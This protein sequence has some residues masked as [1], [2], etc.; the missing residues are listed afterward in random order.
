MVTFCM[1]NKIIIFPWWIKPSWQ[2]ITFSAAIFFSWLFFAFFL[3]LSFFY[4]IQSVVVC[5]SFSFECCL[6]WLT[7]NFENVGNLFWKM[8][9]WEWAWVM[10]DS[11]VV[12]VLNTFERLISRASC[13][14]RSIEAHGAQPSSWCWCAS[15]ASKICFKIFALERQGAQL[16]FSTIVSW[17]TYTSVRIMAARLRCQPTHSLVIQLQSSYN[18]SVQFPHARSALCS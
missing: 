13:E 2:K 4:T 10:S 5:H 17:R 8:L 18:S 15:Q 16:A 1:R 14:R 7:I 9:I 11:Y 12:R 3:F 6:F